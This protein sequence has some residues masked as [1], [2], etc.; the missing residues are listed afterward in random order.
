[1]NHLHVKYLLIGGGACSS[2]AAQA[3][4]Q[5]DTEGSL[6]LVGLESTRPYNRP[7]LSKEF[8]RGTKKRAELFTLPEEWFTTNHVQLRTG[9]RATR[10]DSGRRAVQL[11]TGE[12]ISCDRLLLATGG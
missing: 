10:L 6:L 2:S 7:P 4:R 12:E 11:D 9:Q 3:I 5:R 8:M 1:M